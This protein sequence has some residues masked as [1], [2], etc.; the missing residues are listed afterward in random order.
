[1]KQIH[2]GDVS[3]P[4]DTFATSGTAILGIRASGKTYTAK[5]VAEQLLDYDVPI[6]VF[7][8][9]GVWR[10]LKVAG[11]GKGARGYKVV[12]AGGSDQDLPLTP[13]SAPQ[14][15]RAA[16]RE[17]VSL[18]ID[19]YDRNLSKADWRSIVRSC[20]RTLFFENEGVRHIFLEETPE[21]APQKVIDGET[22]AEVEKL[23][24]MGGN[25]SLGITLISQRAQ[26]VNKAVLDLC[27]NVVLMRQRG[28]HAIDSL[29]KFMDRITPDVAKE[30]AKSLP[31][32]KAGEAWVFSGASDAPVRTRSARLRTFHPD[33]TKPQTRVKIG[34]PADVSS[35]VVNMAKSLEALL[36]EQRQNDP[37]LLREQLRLLHVELDDARKQV[38]Q[39]PSEQDLDAAELA[40]GAAAARAQ[41]DG[42][43]LGRDEARDALLEPAR[44]AAAD[45]ETIAARLRT[46]ADIATAAGAAL[47]AA[48]AAPLPDIAD[49][50]IRPAPASGGRRDR[51][52]IPAG[53]PARK[54]GALATGGPVDAGRRYVEPDTR[55]HFIPARSAAQVPEDVPGLNP[56]QVAILSAC[57]EYPAGLRNEQLT[58]F[59]GLKKS[60]RDL[61]VQQLGRAGLVEKS[62]GVVIA[63]DAGRAALPNR[64]PLP[65]G[66]AL[67]EHWLSKLS[68]GEK[69]IFE[70]LCKAQ[71]RPLTR[72]EL[73]E[74][75][76][77]KKSTRDLYLQ[78]LMRKQIVE[79]VG[80]AQVRAVPMLFA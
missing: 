60:T 38:R 23:V 72:E 31:N 37:E 10:H 9:I 40:I 27:E 52:L 71:G 80:R 44:H 7:D 41:V 47:S 59:S 19:L 35:F 75:V 62:G 15:V 57:I 25:A 21:Y 4:L 49:V 26:E 30:V 56:G 32:M 20:F 6:V 79:A 63:T 51:V 39:G 11:E 24:R 53:K 55:E 58:M 1:M 13:D 34:K 64:R 67:R 12:V 36:V 74:A 28:A 45:L 2:I 22:Y 3:F 48:I 43:K 50:E 17:H 73:G 14:I 18:V 61:Y 33:R 29:E 54:S 68:G 46:A 70:T 16:I 69:Q 77:L 65:R 8:A 76:N 66:R 78:Q 42:R 5:G